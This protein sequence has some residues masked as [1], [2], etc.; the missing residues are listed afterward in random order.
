MKISSIIFLQFFFLALTNGLASTPVNKSFDE[1]DVC[2][3]SAGIESWLAGTIIP[4]NELIVS[5]NNSEGEFNEYVE[6]NFINDLLIK[7][8]WHSNDGNTIDEVTSV[9]INFSSNFGIENWALSI[10]NADTTNGTYWVQ[11]GV[12]GDECSEKTLLPLLTDEVIDEPSNPPIQ[13]TGYECGDVYSPEPYSNETVLEQLSVDEVFL[14]NGFPVL[15][16]HVNNTVNGQGHYTGNGIVPLPFKDKVVAVTFDVFI[17]KDRIAFAGTVIGESDDP[18]HYPDFTLD[19]EPFNFGGEICIPPDEVEDNQQIDPVTGLNPYGFNTETG[20]NAATGTQFDPNGFDINGVHQSTGTVFNECGCNRE[21]SDA[22]GQICDPSCGPNAQSQALADSLSTT[23]ENRL[24][25]LIDSIR[26]LTVTEITRLNCG[27]VRADIEGLVM[28]LGFEEEF[29]YGENREFIDAGMYLNFT[30]E[31]TPLLLNI[32]RNPQVELL[33]EKHINLFAC[34]REEYPLTLF[35]LSLEGLT[36]EQITTLNNFLLAEIAAWTTYQ[37]NEF[38][39]SSEGLNRWLTLQIALWLRSLNENDENTG[40]IRFSPRDIYQHPEDIIKDAFDFKQFATNSSHY[41]Y[42]SMKSINELYSGKLSFDEVAE[43]FK[44]GALEIGGIHRSYF[45]ESLAKHQLM[46]GHNSEMLMPI[47]VEKEIANL[48]Y[49]IYLDNIVFTPGTATLDAFLI[50]TDP[51]T[52]RRMVFSG[53]NI[54]FN[55]AGTAGESSLRLDSDV[56]FRLNNAAMLILKGGDSTRVSW[57]CNGF[58]SMDVNAQIEFCR[59]FITPLDPATLNPLH[60]SIRYR[61]DLLT[62][63]TSWLEFSLTVDSPKPFSV[64][65]FEN[66]KWR[67]ENLIVDMSSTT[68]PVFSPIDGYHS[69]FWDGS[70]MS[71][72]WKGFYLENLSA[73]FASEMTIG[74]EVTTVGIQNVLIDGGG[75]TGRLTA[76]D[77]FNM[78]EG[79]MGGWPFSIDTFELTIINNKFAG[80]GLGGDINIPIFEGGTAYHAT[81]YPNNFYRFSVSP[82]QNEKV[83]LFLATANLQASSNLAV[84][85]SHDDGFHIVATLNGNLSILNDDESEGRQSIDLPRLTFQNFQLSN[86]AP[87]FSPGVWGTG[88]LGGTQDKLLGGFPLRLEEVVPYRGQSDSTAGLNIGISLSLSQDIDLAA[89]GSFA[90]QGRL[91]DDNGRQKWEYERFIFNS[92]YVDGSFPGVEY[93]RGGLEWYGQTAPHPVYGKGFRGMLE[94]EFSGIGIE[95]SAAAQFGQLAPAGGEEFKYFFV[96]A[97]LGLGEAALPIG[98]LLITGFAGGVSNRMIA[99]HSPTPNFTQSGGVGLPP[100]GTSFSGV[101]YTPSYPTGLSLRAQALLALANDEIMNGSVGLEITFNSII[102]DNNGNRSGGGISDFKILGQGQMLAVPDLELPVAFIENAVEKPVAVQSVISLYFDIGYDFN[103]DVLQGNL[104]TFVNTPFIRGVGPGGRS[105][106]AE[107]YV[108]PEKWYIY[109]GT[110]SDPAGL[111]LDIPGLNISSTSYLDIGTEVPSMPPL[112]TE[113]SSIAYLVNQNESLRNSGGGFIMGMRL[114]AEVGLKLGPFEANLAGGLGFDVMLRKYPGYT[115]VGSNEEI[116]INGW[117]AAGQAYV[118]MNGEFRAFGYNILSLGMAAVLQAK[119]PNPFYAQATVGVRVKIGP[120]QVRKSLKI[121]VGQDCNFVAPD[122][123]DGIGMQVVLFV[124]PGDNVNNI[125][126]LTEITADLALELNKPYRITGLNGDESV[127]RVKPNYNLTTISSSYGN[128]PFSSEVGP[129]GTQLVLR[130]HFALPPNDSITVTVVM[131]IY[132]DNI[133]IGEEVKTTSFVTTDGYDYLPESNITSAYPFDGMFNFYPEEYNIHEGFINLKAG[134]PDLLLDQGGRSTVV[135]LTSASGEETILPLTNSSTSQLIKFD[136]P[137]DIFNP[138]SLYKIELVRGVGLNPE[139]PPS[140]LGNLLNPVPLGNPPAVTDDTNEN[141]LAIIYTAYFRTSEF[142]TFNQKIDQ[143]PGNDQGQVD[144]LAINLREF[145]RF[146]KLETEGAN[147][148]EK[149]IEFELDLDNNYVRYVRREIDDLISLL[150]NAYNCEGCDELVDYFTSDAIFEKAVTLDSPPA[151]SS[152]GREDFE[153]NELLNPIASRQGIFFDLER[154]ARGKIN[155]LLQFRAEDIEE[156][157]DN[158]NLNCM[159][160]TPGSSTDPCGDLEDAVNQVA[161]PVDGLYSGSYQVSIKYRLPNGVPTSIYP[162]TFNYTP[163][164]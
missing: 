138:E 100:L 134:Q 29:I 61:I 48:I 49:T 83:D 43:R 156:A 78:D 85:Y 58:V 119:F 3:L 25:G 73:T 26:T 141:D 161:R 159:E 144:V 102:T 151:A 123:E 109:V 162:I 149:L 152:L 18:T 131:D 69:P 95:I 87:Y 35:L 11:V 15:T 146:D 84:E 67:L 24:V 142:R 143:L 9:N 55:P 52:N 111:V 88:D 63:V 82:L 103:N 54:G 13:L 32:D 40:S 164:N 124:S 17:N 86:R 136:L 150:D 115:C 45:L 92:F 77:L 7:L 79:S 60:D 56:E 133:K 126:T 155:Y 127:Y 5:F 154:A 117:Y 90:I 128:I 65:K 27:S 47:T 53:M 98:P 42:A 113:V 41:D 62:Q 44:R 19:Y 91:V 137:P 46:N 50:I 72:Q 51:E 59:N 110:P 8:Y 10:T 163:Q 157:M 34:D 70:V 36:S 6:S 16:K 71:P 1:T 93:I 96:D 101:H 33:E 114:N 68:T 23:L 4:L 140:A 107:L 75:F 118:Y 105:N 74:T 38:G 145:E 108:G 22:N 31:P 2:E 97:K 30:S 21:G 20:V 160:A 39:Q 89:A 121:A 135:R 153:A 122:G 129:G 104:T 132:Q 112:P 139:E 120:L 158:L 28:A 106:W 64:T 66:I 94:A 148:V 116:G 81:M 125:E 76:G 14:I 12:N 80:G 57:D 130:P 147:E 99:N 37:Y